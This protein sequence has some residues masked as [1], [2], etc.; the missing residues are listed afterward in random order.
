MNATLFATAGGRVLL[1]DRGSLLASRDDGGALVVVPPRIVWERSE[2]DAAELAGWSFLVA[3]TGRA[4]LDTLPQLE[5]GCINYWEAGNWALHDAAAPPGPK[6]APAFRQMHLHLLGRSR[7]ATRPG[8][9]LGE[10][11]RFPAFAER[12][13]WSAGFEP[14]HAAE[15]RGIVSQVESRLLQRYGVPPE[16][17]VPWTICARCGYP[18]AAPAAAA[19]A[20]APD[21]EVCR[22]PSADT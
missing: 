8:W 1:P 16:H 11:P 21:C 19:P 6:T 17:I 4:M 15:C 22:A 13:T 12:H 2:L 3:A 20:A 5:G 18:S 9:Q 14:L 7:L 10:S